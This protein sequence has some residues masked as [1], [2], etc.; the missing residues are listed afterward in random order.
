MLLEPSTGIEQRQILMRRLVAHEHGVFKLL[1]GQRCDAPAFAQ[2]LDERVRP[3]PRPAAGRSRPGTFVSPVSPSRSSSAARRVSASTRVAPS[4]IASIT[5]IR[6]SV[7]SRSASV[8]SSA[9]SQGAGHLPRLS[10]RSLTAARPLPDRRS[11]ALSDQAQR[12]PCVCRAPLVNR[13]AGHERAA[14]SISRQNIHAPRSRYIGPMPR[15]PPHST[16]RSQPLLNSR[17]RC[18]QIAP[19]FDA[20]PAAATAEHLAGATP[21]SAET[22][23]IDR[24]RY[25]RNTMPIRPNNHPSQ[26]SR[27]R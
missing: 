7:S 21:V 6:P 22:K 23:P 11:P 8:T 1:A 4:A 16:E 15:N 20:G 27:R 26:R 12:R 13:P 10:F 24:R 18:D 14:L 3:P 5:S 9:S 25:D 19:W 17:S 2:H